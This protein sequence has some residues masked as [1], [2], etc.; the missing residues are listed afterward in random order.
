MEF[1]F[2]LCSLILYVAMFV[3]LT[4]KLEI[5]RLPVKI[6]VAAVGAWCIVASFCVIGLI[7]T[8]DY[9][10]G[11][12]ALVFGSSSLVTAALVVIFGTFAGVAAM[13]NKQKQEHG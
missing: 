12:E 10:D 6:V 9:T 1:A 7:S 2:E 3:L 8:L 5:Q 4:Q 11:S 13:K